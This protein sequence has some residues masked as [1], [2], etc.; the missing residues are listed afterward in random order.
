MQNLMELDHG[1]SELTDAFIFRVVQI[2]SSEH[3]LI[4]VCRP[5]TAILKKFVEADPM[6]A[7]GPHVASSSKAVPSPPPGSVYKFGFEVVFAQMRKEKRLLE[8]VVNRLGSA[9]T[10]MALYRYVRARSTPSC[11]VPKAIRLPQHD[12][13]QFAARACDGCTVGRIHWR[14]APAERAQG[15]DR[16]CLLIVFCLDTIDCNIKQR[17]MSSHTIEDLTSCILDFQANMVRVTYRRKVTVVEPE[18]EPEH[19][20]MLNY[21]WVNSKVREEPDGEGGTL[22]W[23]KLGCDSEDLAQEFHEVGVLG[24]ECLVSCASFLSSSLIWKH[25]AGR[26]RIERCC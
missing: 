25:I 19:D 1:W 24:L 18:L 26:I 5:A 22:K 6:S 23:R 14:A 8:T 16:K 15:C 20:S 4:N 2:L 7:P 17:L 12:A 3:S 10:T 21:V 13:D 9:D 11:V